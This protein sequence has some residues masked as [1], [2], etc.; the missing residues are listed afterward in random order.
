MSIKH[1]TNPGLKPWAEPCSPF[2]GKLCR[3][4][5]M[6]IHLDIRFRRPFRALKTAREISRL[7]KSYDARKEQVE[8]TSDQNQIDQEDKRPCQ[9]M[10]DNG[11][12]ISYKSAR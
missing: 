7:T 6:F 10:P 2:R 4:W 12:F 9:I 8:H 1:I 5:F 3:P 11:P